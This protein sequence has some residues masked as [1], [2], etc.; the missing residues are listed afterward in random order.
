VSLTIGVDIGGTKVAAGVVDP[1]GTILARVRHDTPSHDP[2]EVCRVVVECI[3][4][5]TGGTPA[6]EVMAVGIGAAGFV[7]AA[8]STVL[9]APNLAWRNE[10]LKAMIEQLTGLSVVVENDANAAA[11]GETRFGAGHGEQY[12]V[13]VTVGT[14]IGGGIVRG[15]ELYRGAFGVAAE[16]GHILIEP[17]GRQ[18][19]CGNLGCL[20]QYASGNALVREA[21]E[22]ADRAPERAGLL[23]ELAGGKAGDITGPQVTEAARQGDETAVAAFEVIG[24][25]LGSGM[26]SLAAVLDPRIFI[27]GGGVSAA[28]ELLV[29]PARAAFAEQ[30]TAHGYRPM[31]EIRVAELGPDAG[32]VGAAD[33]ARR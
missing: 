4:E 23:L 7:D 1:G 15:G 18:C 6:Y 11:W 31:A 17:G 32:L 2:D 5:L 9:F 27:V 28:G 22:R 12:A 26:A 8:R 25:W 33:L 20:E 16:V 24:T 21:R 10:P 14:G 13:T 19:G 29:G 3:R 30:L